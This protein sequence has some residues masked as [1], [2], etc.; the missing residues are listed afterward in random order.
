MEATIKLTE[1]QLINLIEECADYI[2]DD[3]VL[4]RIA[5]KML[6]AIYR[7]DAYMDWDKIIKYA[8]TEKQRVE[9]L[10][11]ERFS[12]DFGDDFREEAV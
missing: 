7:A 5:L 12:D 10:S 1:K 9:S 4:T 3:A 11:L 2:D 6:K 8:T